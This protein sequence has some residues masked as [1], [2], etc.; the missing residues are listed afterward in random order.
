MALKCIVISHNGEIPFR[1]AEF[2]D[3]AR[4]FESLGCFKSLDAASEHLELASL[5]FL[6]MEMEQVAN[7]MG[8]IMTMNTRP[9]LLI[10]APEE[11]YFIES[12][13]VGLQL[14]ADLGRAPLDPAKLAGSMP[15]SNPAKIVVPSAESTPFKLASQSEKP[16]WMLLNPKEWNLELAHACPDSIYVR[17][18]ACIKRIRL[19]ELLVVEAQKDYL[20][21][22]TTTGSYRVLKSLKKFETHLIPQ[23]HQRIHRSFI[24]Q[25]SAIHTIEN[26]QV[27]L[28]NLDF[29]IPIGPS[30]RK[31]L[32][33]NLE[34]L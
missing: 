24:V 30:F 11:T 23:M 12:S 13:K 34:V 7:M 6:L 15:P 25:V 31:D 4:I 14:L 26:E 28:D 33:A 22:I 1:I 19:S 8:A 2:L 20:N 5:Q 27:W 9:K 16:F 3:N 21:L 17:T 29:P 32:L 10:F 18:E